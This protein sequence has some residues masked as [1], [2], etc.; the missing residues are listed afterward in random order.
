MSID[1]FDNRAACGVRRATLCRASC[2]R[3]LL[4]AALCTPNSAQGQSIC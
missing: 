4:N 2:R 1:S 3:C